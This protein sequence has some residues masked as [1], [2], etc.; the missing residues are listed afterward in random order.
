M[1]QKNLFDSQI[2]KTDRILNN[3]NVQYLII[4]SDGTR[5]GNIESIPQKKRSFK[6]K[7]GEM[8]FYIEPFMKELLTGVEIC[9]PYG[10]FDKDRLSGAMAGFASDNWGKGSY[11][12]KCKKDGI[13][14]MRLL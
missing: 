9:V 13:H 5:Y 12:Y 8:K 1:K 14:I 10:K 3:L 11:T 7:W 4:T 6:Y 2:E